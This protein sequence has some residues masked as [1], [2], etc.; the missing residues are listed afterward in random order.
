MSLEDLKHEWRTEL[1]RSLPPAEID[2]FLLAVQQRYAELERQVHGRDVREILAALIVVGGFAA[3]WPIYRSSPVAIAGVVLIICGAALIVYVLMSSRSREPESFQTSVLQCARHR[4]AW[5]DRQI[6]LLRNVVWWYVAPI[7][8]GSLLFGWG[9]AHG[10]IVAFT[11]HAAIV[12]AVC[13]SIVV[14]NHSAVRRSLQPV[15]DEVSRLIDSLE[16]E[17][18]IT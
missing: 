13:A 12:L 16:K 5:L 14:L 2:P 3:L 6:V 10:S 17:G 8:A 1:D 15:R 18:S 9:L 4:R 7:C 11:V